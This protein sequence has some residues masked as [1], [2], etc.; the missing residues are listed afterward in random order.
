M[1]MKNV[2]CAGGKGTYS[3]WLHGS[4]NGKLVRV[5]QYTGSEKKRVTPGEVVR[6]SYV[7][8]GQIGSGK[9]IQYPLR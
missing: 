8:G 3:I 2:R 6:L 7:D 1:V 9:K 4:K 5:R